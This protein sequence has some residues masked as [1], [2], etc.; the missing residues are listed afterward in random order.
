MTPDQ[1]LVQQA[2]SDEIVDHFKDCFVRCTQ[3]TDGYYGQFVN[4]LKKIREARDL[5]LQAVAVAEVAPS[6]DGVPDGSLI[7]Q[8]YE[9]IVVEQTRMFFGRYI[10]GTDSSGQTFQGLMQTIRTLRADALR[11]VAK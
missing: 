5:V 4:G 7:Q 11:L 1:L 2:Y 10:D 9:E 3:G 6:P 8:G